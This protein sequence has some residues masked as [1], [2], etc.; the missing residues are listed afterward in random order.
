MPRLM[1]VALLAMTGCTVLYRTGN[2]SRSGDRVIGVGGTAPGTPIPPGVVIS[3][4]AT[5]N[6]LCSPDDTD[7][8]HTCPAKAGPDQR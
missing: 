7:P 3:I 2:G 1:L 4:D 5:D 8:Q 6:G